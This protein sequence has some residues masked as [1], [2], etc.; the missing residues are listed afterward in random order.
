VVVL[1]VYCQGQ[2]FLIVE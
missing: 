1:A 2:W